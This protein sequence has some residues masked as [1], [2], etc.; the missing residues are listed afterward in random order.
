MTIEAAA[1]GGELWLRDIRGH[2]S[3]VRVKAGDVLVA[4]FQ[5]FGL[6]RTSAGEVWAF[7]YG[8]GQGV[9][10]QR[11][12]NG[13]RERFSVP[14]QDAG[15]RGLAELDGPAIVTRRL[16]ITPKRTIELSD[17]VPYRE[18]TLSFAISGGALWVGKNAGEWYGGLRRYS[19][20]TGEAVRVPLAELRRGV[21]ETVTAVVPERSGCVLASLGLCHFGEDGLVVRACED[22]RL[23]VAADWKAPSSD[24]WSGHSAVFSLLSNGKTTLAS[25]FAG[26]RRVDAPRDPPVPWKFERVCGLGIARPAKG[27]L[28]ISSQAIRHAAVGGA[29]PFFIA[30]DPSLTE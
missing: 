9:V 20:A 15:P 29:S 13:W 1:A 17:D 30:D 26:L 2:L 28:A 18:V 5:A 7:E 27:V 3:G 25:T 14:L 10:W 8:N 4:P 21:V 6:V 19:L 16:L 22:G 11:E 23:E 12:R 24:S